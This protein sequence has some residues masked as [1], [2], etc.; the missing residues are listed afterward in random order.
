MS[1]RQLEAKRAM[2]M[3]AAQ[4]RRLQEATV[5]ARSKTRADAALRIMCRVCGAVS[6]E[7]KGRHKVVHF[8]R[9]RFEPLVV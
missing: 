4:Q 3:A 1:N 6:G 7:C 9:P 5:A 2:V 8:R